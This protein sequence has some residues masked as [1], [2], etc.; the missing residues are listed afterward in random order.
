MD[1]C[2]CGQRKIGH[3]DLY[4]L[5][6]YNIL[7]VDHLLYRYGAT[8]IRLHA[9]A[10]YCGIQ[11]YVHFLNGCHGPHFV[12]L[13]LQCRGGL[14]GIRIAAVSQPG[15]HWMTCPS[16]GSIGIESH[17]AE[18]FMELWLAVVEKVRKMITKSGKSWGIYSKLQVTREWITV[19]LHLLLKI[20]PDVYHCKLQ[21]IPMVPRYAVSR[22]DDVW[23]LVCRDTLKWTTADI[24]CLMEINRKFFHR[25]VVWWCLSQ[26]LAGMLYETH[27]NYP[28][29]S[30]DWSYYSNWNL[31]QKVDFATFELIKRM[32][33]GIKDSAGQRVVHTLQHSTSHPTTRS[34]HD[35]M[36]QAPNKNCVS[37]SVG[38]Y[39]KSTKKSTC[40]RHQ[41][42]ES[43]SCL[44]PE[45]VRALGALGSLQS[46]KKLSVEKRQETN[47]WSNEEK[48]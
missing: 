42:N 25:N 48:E 2:H 29:I 22:S 3:E 16:F 47:F 40:R 28:V 43:K 18:V 45:M 5:Q 38:K 37:L 26:H 41:A 6:L 46:K 17:Q 35:T 14:P 7:L 1:G 13:Q 33:L 10:Y 31:G 24:S 21:V 8:H 20:Y 11:F 15:P 34:T 36:V 32:H 23:L 19:N 39:G 4:V 9:A 30:Y 27:A 12:C 44:E